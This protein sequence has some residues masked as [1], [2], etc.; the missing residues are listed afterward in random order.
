MSS[1]FVLSNYAFYGTNVGG[2][3]RGYCEFTLSWDKNSYYEPYLVRLS[4]VAKSNPSRQCTLLSIDRVNGTANFRCGTAQAP[5]EFTDSFIEMNR[6][7]TNRMW[8]KYGFILEAYVSQTVLGLTRGLGEW[9]CRIDPIG[10]YP[11]GDGTPYYGNLVEAASY[12]GFDFL[13]GAAIAPAADQTNFYCDDSYEE[14]NMLN[15]TGTEQ[16]PIYNPYEAVQ[17][18]SLVSRYYGH[19]VFVNVSSGDFEDTKFFHWLAANADVEVVGDASSKAKVWC[20]EDADYTMWH[21]GIYGEK[22]IGAGNIMNSETWDA[23]VYG[24]ANAWQ[25]HGYNKAPVPVSTKI[26]ITNVDF[27]SVKILGYVHTCDIETSQFALSRISVYVTS[28]FKFLN[29]DTSATSVAA[30]VPFSERYHWELT[31]AD[32]FVS[33]VWYHFDPAT[34]AHK[35][36]YLSQ[37]PLPTRAEYVSEY[38]ETE[39]AHM[40]TLGFGPYWNTQFNMVR[41]LGTDGGTG[42][43]AYPRTGTLIDVT[44]ADTKWTTL[45]DAVLKNPATSNWSPYSAVF[46]VRGN[47]FRD[48]PGVVL[49]SASIGEM[50][51]TNNSYICGSNP[52][53]NS[54]DGYEYSVH[55][56]E[57]RKKVVV[58]NNTEDC[59]VQVKVCWFGSSYPSDN[60]EMSSYLSVPKAV[61][62]YGTSLRHFIPKDQFA[63]ELVSVQNGIGFTAGYT[64]LSSSYTKAAA[65]DPDL[66]IDGNGFYNYWTFV[67]QYIAKVWQPLYQHG[68]APDKSAA[69]GWSVKHFKQTKLLIGTEVLQGYNAA[70]DLAKF[71][72]A[73]G[74]RPLS[75]A[76][77][78]NAGNPDVAYN[79]LDGSRCTQ[80][81]TGGQYGRNNLVA[82]IRWVDSFVSVNYTKV[83]DGMQ[84]NLNADRSS[85]PAAVQ[86]TFT[87]SNG[88]GNPTQN[89][90]TNNGTYAGVT[91]LVTLEQAGTYEFTVVVNDGNGHTATETLSFIV[92]AQRVFCVDASRTYTNNLLPFDLIHADKANWTFTDDPAVNWQTGGVTDQIKMDGQD[93]NGV[94][95][96][97]AAQRTVTAPQANARYYIKLRVAK[98][99]VDARLN[100]DLEFSVYAVDGDGTLL[101]GDTAVLKGSNL[102]TKRNKDFSVTYGVVSGYLSVKSNTA[103]TFY[104]ITNNVLSGQAYK[105]WIDAMYLAAADEEAD[106]IYQDLRL[107]IRHHKPNDL[108]QLAGTADGVFFDVPLRVAGK[109]I[110]VN[111]TGGWDPTSYSEV[112]KKYVTQDWTLY[113][114]YLNYIRFAYFKRQR[115]WAYNAVSANMYVYFP[116][117]LGHFYVT[118][119]WPDL[120]NAWAYDGMNLQC[121]LH[122]QLTV[123]NI[124]FV[125]LYRAGDILAYSDAAI[126]IDNGLVIDNIQVEDCLEGL[127]VTTKHVDLEV[128]NCE[129][130]RVIG[131][132]I[133]VA[134]KRSVEYPNRKV[135]IHHNTFTDCGIP[136][137]LGTQA[138]NRDDDIWRRMP[139]FTD[140]PKW[141]VGFDSATQDPYWN[142]AYDPHMAPVAIVL[143]EDN[144]GLEADLEIDNNNFVST[145]SSYEALYDVVFAGSNA[146]LPD[147]KVKIH[148]N[149]SNTGKDFIGVHRMGLRSLYYCPEMPYLHNGGAML[150]ANNVVNFSAYN[151]AASLVTWLDSNVNHYF[152]VFGN[153][154]ENMRSLVNFVEGTAFKEDSARGK[155]VV[156]VEDNITDNVGCALHYSGKSSMTPQQWEALKS[157][158]HVANNGVGCQEKHLT[159]NWLSELPTVP[160]WTHNLLLHHGVPPRQ[161]LA[162]FQ[163]V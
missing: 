30:K 8:K 116:S 58:E 114:S 110:T 113:K 67:N 6:V 124:K 117:E 154:V 135:H 71:I 120:P 130:T 93:H 37:C 35:H 112:L 122:A 101:F 75:N 102:V 141:A 65:Q 60:I 108:I 159:W 69:Q 68:D 162:G 19:K 32:S 57:G 106:D 43:F 20:N 94:G 38:G 66:S 153:T 3:H 87:W 4:G 53:Y 143:D 52:T 156:V 95:V 64:P 72:D 104:L 11:W 27:T 70:F 121:I 76:S 136:N 16:N 140:D 55:H 51:Y 155:P 23:S 127:R 96:N 115:D 88:V 1:E 48:N 79:D 47:S 85:W 40:D 157:W 84:V 44:D 131:G 139:S 50:H 10:A 28:S 12:I 118:N 111:V 46:E 92:S 148:D 17:L 45:L 29:N 123:K 5:F 33:G 14:R 150:Q 90:F 161:I 158:Y 147:A 42:R 15:A 132:T 34:H 125:G 126:D 149:V 26:K 146:S 25:N 107:A 105:T 36:W 138:L 62:W 31:S 80:G 160:A 97:W 152:A 83:Y 18:A 119:E 74:L 109:N 59:D 89:T 54:Y 39:A 61:Q 128:K 133:V 77:Y 98:Q 78:C 100:N 22:Y 81:H 7:S 49:F 21:F 129:G 151:D 13:T 144:N 145:S 41:M 163:S 9:N 134:S 73:Y 86:P 142:V 63:V 82:R 2:V 24:G 103:V 137:T 91:Q 56:V 99:H